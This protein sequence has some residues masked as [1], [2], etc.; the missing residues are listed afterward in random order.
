[1]PFKVNPDI[2]L[3]D[4]LLLRPSAF[5]ALGI[6]LAVFEK[7]KIES[8]ITSLI[9]DRKGIKGVSRSHEDGRAIDF[10]IK[11]IP[12][13]L[14]QKITNEL[15]EEFAEE[16]GA[17]GKESG[18]PELAVLHDAGSGEHI[19]IQVRIGLDLLEII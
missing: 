6:V 11:R 3:K 12:Y 18:L 2:V 1:M 4:F 14:A 7:Y 19:H 16:I 8:V 5:I 10:S 13:A 9:S 15:N 17:I